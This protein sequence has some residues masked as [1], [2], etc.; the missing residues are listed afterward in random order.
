MTTGALEMDEDLV[1]AQCALEPIRTPGAIQPHGYLLA[2]DTATLV[3]QHAS[4]NV[5]TL[6][7]R[8]LG[9]ILGRRLSDWLDTADAVT[10][11]KVLEVTE[12]LDSDAP[13]SLTLAGQLFDGTLHRINGL[14]ILE[15]EPH[16]APVV[17]SEPVL[18]R[19]LRRL[20]GAAG[21][22][23]LQEAS[24]REVRELT[25]F[26]RVVIY[27]FNP[28][29]HGSVLAEARA[30]DV[31]AY[32]GLNFPASDIPTQAREL[33]KQNWLRMI[34]DVDYVPV[35]IVGSQSVSP[36][37]PLDLTFSIL[38]SVSPIH[39]EYMRHMGTA[40]SMSISLIRDGELW[41]LISCVHR[42]PRFI[43]RDIRTACASIGRLLSLQISAMESL[44]ESKLIDANQKLLAPL[45]AQ[46]NR[47]SQA[48]LESLFETP[49]H[50][51][52]LT[53]A[54]GVTVVVGEDIRSFGKCPSSKQLKG[55][56]NWAAT[57]A[58]GNG[59]FETSNLALRYPAAREFAQ[60]ASGMLAIILPKPVLNMVLW[61]RPEV[62]QTVH[63]A[64][65]PNK[66]PSLVPGT[67]MLRLS[68]RHSFDAWKTLLRQHSADWG[69]H[70]IEAAKELRRSAIELD[71]ADQVAREQKAVASR[72]ELVA[73]VSHDLRSPLSV[74]VLQASMMIRTLIADTNEPSG[75]MLAAAQSIQRATSRMAEML[76]DLLDL[77]TIEQ[78]RYIVDLAPLR[79]EDIFEDSSAL[80]LPIA[81]AKRITLTFRGE[82]GLVVSADGER[83]YQVISNIVGNALKFTAE[84]GIV[85]VLAMPDP[86]PESG[87]VRFAIA[88]NGSG[89]PPDQLGH[90]FE[91]YWRVRDAN[92]T[93]SGL[94]LYI[95]SGIVQAHGGRIWAESEVGVGSTFCF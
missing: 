16:V 10:V 53:D 5:A 58:M 12:L 90:I 69:A 65:D 62:T 30:G 31:T 7:A 51:L 47:S 89:M 25:G 77:S 9:E 4:A 84:G 56:V 3:L 35:A 95:A 39:R 57:Q 29:G 83:L 20:Q 36:N 73:V 13:L 23:A 22:G 82:P 76:R 87:L 93:G 19:A 66:T 6:V 37:S 81:E 48:V 64:G 11:I 61:F 54:S 8:D 33:Y 32:L 17:Q 42:A 91:R 52:R 1:L 79:V 18:A 92:P 78:G 55:L 71:L 68:P 50:L 40:S 38:R 74:V 85:D 43:P 21:I 44:R 24:V 86:N 60:I 46:M 72:D 59:C 75:R 80:L 94:G 2:F 67:T 34:P 28:D 41:G 45:V 88:D 27:A 63:W 49:D 14:S 15:L 26:D 70:R